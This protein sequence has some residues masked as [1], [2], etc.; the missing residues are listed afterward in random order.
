MFWIKKFRKRKLQSVM[1]FLLVSI[2]ALMMTGSL[3]IL[4]S[5]D[6]PYNDLAEE[7]DAPQLKVYPYENSTDSGKDWVEELEKQDS[8]KK[9][10]EV[11]RHYVTEKISANKKQMDVFV[12]LVKYDKDLYGKDRI[13]AGAMDSL[14]D[15]EC[16]IASTLANTQD[17]KLGDTITVSYDG[18]DFSYRVN[19]I[20]ADAYSLNTSFQ[21]E[22]L[23]NNLPKELFDEPYYAVYAKGEKT[24]QDVMEEYVNTHDGLLDGNFNTLEHGISNAHITENI[25]GA[26]LLVLS[27]VIF[28]VA[29]V[30][31]RYMI[32]NAM[33]RDT[34]TIAVYKALGY[35]SKD[36]QGIYITFYQ[37]IVFTGSMVGILCSPLITSAFMS[38]AFANL[39]ETH[40]VAGIFQG[41]LCGSVI[42]AFAFL[43]VYMELK[44]IRNMKPAELLGGTD[45]QL[46]IKKTKPQE[47][48]RGIK[49]SPFSMALRLIKR[50]K[51]NTALIILTCFLS[52]Y[53]VNLAIVCFDNIQGMSADNYYWL[54]FDKHDITIQ[55]KGDQERFYQIIEEMKKDP[56]VKK[57]VK[58]NL[59]AGFCIPYEQS[60]SAMVY[61]DYEGLEF[62]LLAGREPQSSNET[63]IGNYYAKQL[64]K[65]IGDYIE[66]YLSPEIKTNLLIVGT[67]QGFYNMGQVIRLKSSLLEENDIAL[68]YAEAS[69]MLKDGTDREEFL[70]KFNQEYKG[71]AEAL[72]R[73]NLYSNVIAEIV[74][75][76]KAALGP[77]VALALLIGTLNLIYIIYLKNLNSIKIHSIYKSMGYPVSHLVKMNCFYVGIIAV[78]S[79]AVAIPVF[80]FCFPRTMVL[81]MSAFGFAEYRVTFRPVTMLLGNGGAVAI[82]LVGV[83]LSGRELYKNHIETLVSE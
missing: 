3:I 9:V 4:S 41:V 67:C 46:G 78:I 37:V 56:Q 39:G 62:P 76:Q 71:E 54:G 19:A 6:K 22:I 35:T 29:S 16:A 23:V 66:V 74:D 45:N 31:I 77:F 12:S 55:N 36:I 79:I 2:C 17:I 25:L 69:V 34:K 51:K 48:S 61:E 47:G 11:H 60:V 21:M 53:M 58:R 32:R 59:E 15:G 14:A 26:I 30:M 70:E 18:K 80:V 8:V 27:I 64:N 28:L 20:F 81:A 50:D 5:L 42:N 13:L 63:V 7:T 33:V 75:P 82:F 24:G 68:D 72:K 43:Q 40:A 65:Q 10:L 38:A 44:K 1:I 73:E 57:V 52:I 83:L 49:F